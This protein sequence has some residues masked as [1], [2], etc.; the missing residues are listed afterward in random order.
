M[1]IRG[2]QVPFLS[3]DQKFLRV[4]KL[5]NFQPYKFTSYSVNT[6]ADRSFNGRIGFDNVTCQNCDTGLVAFFS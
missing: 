3:T 5:K 2:L 6:G 1:A 4:L